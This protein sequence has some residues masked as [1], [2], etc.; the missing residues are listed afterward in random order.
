M[1]KL[2]FDRNDLNDKTL[3]KLKVVLTDEQ[4]QRIGADGRE[5][6]TH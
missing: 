2:T 6:G 3:A 4:A 5:Q 1:E